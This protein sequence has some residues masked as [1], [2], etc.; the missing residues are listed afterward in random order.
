METYRI[1]G[2]LHRH[3]MQGDHEIELIIGG[4]N[5]GGGNEENKNSDDEGGDNEEKDQGSNNKK[6]KRTLKFTNG[7]GQRTLDKEENINL[8]QFDTELMIDPLFR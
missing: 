4:N 1:L 3:G 8:V 2:G 7:A 6:K 5:P